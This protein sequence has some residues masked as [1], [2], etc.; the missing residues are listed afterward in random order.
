MKYTAL[1]F[2]MMSVFDIVSLLVSCEHNLTCL[3]YW[4]KTTWDMGCSWTTDLSKKSAGP[5]FKTDF[6]TIC[7]QLQQAHF[8]IAK[9]SETKWKQFPLLRVIEFWHYRPVLSLK[10]WFAMDLF[11][12]GVRDCHV[13]YSLGTLFIRCL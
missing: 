4:N 3:S 2:K 6:S 7:P 11:S 5:W 1:E 8:G 10:K 13:L 12:H 9:T